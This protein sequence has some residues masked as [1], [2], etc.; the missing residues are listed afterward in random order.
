[1][2]L[3]KWISKNDALL[4]LEIT[5]GSLFCGSP[6]SYGELIEKCRMLLSFDYAVSGFIDMR[7]I[8]IEN[9]VSSSI[10]S[11]FPQEFLETYTANKYHLVDPLLQEFRKNYEPQSSVDLKDLYNDDEAKKILA[12]RKDFGI[13]KTFLHGVCETDMECQTAFAMAGQ[14]MENNH[15]TKNI[16]NYL[17]P[18]LALTL[19]VLIPFPVE[20]EV[21]SLTHS[22]LEILKWLKEGKSSWEI[23]SILNKSER[24]IRFHV[25]NIIKKLNAA[26]RTHAVAIALEKKLIA[27]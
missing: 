20:K 17:T 18:Y 3:G 11:G 13:E 8:S 14:K 5:N 16:I 23:S 7:A 9:I 15:R 10:N 12:L 19:K 24:A 22:E 1:L 25:D 6:E 4:L 26:N 2:E 21:R 27:L